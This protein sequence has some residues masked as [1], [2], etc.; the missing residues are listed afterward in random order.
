MKR[1]VLVSFLGTGEYQETDYRFGESTCRTKF[2]PLAAKQFFPVAELYI[3][4]TSEAENKHGA[5]LGTSCAYQKIDIPVGRTEAE[6][7]DIFSAMTERVPLNKDDELILDVTHGFRSQPMLALAAIAFIKAMKDVK[8]RHILYGAY[9]ARND[10]GTPVFDLLPFL[11]IIEWSAGFNQFKT[12]G[13]MKFFGERLRQIHNKTYTEKHAVKSKSLRKIGNLLESLTK[14][15]ETVRVKESIAGAFLFGSEIKN[16]NEDLVNHPDTKPFSLM[17]EGL[18][19]EIARLG[20]AEDKIFSKEGIRVQKDIIAYY[21]LSGQYQQALTL[22]REFLV[23]AFIAKD[24]PETDE[25]L[26]LNKENREKAEK[27]LSECMMKLKDN[28]ELAGE[29]KPYAEF[30]SR[31]TDLRNDI[32]HGSMRLNPIPAVRI[33]ENTKKLFEDLSTRIMASA[34]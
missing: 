24:Y 27:K 20:C 8:V 4:M 28:K 33:I 19:T 29:E 1:T 31:V 9:E 13:D 22:M 11:D 18:R 32:N 26:I 10:N 3:V 23:S 7:W 30:W 2:F 15:L 17:M 6:M 16:A 12:H 14:S 21:L 34:H 5:Q 25:S